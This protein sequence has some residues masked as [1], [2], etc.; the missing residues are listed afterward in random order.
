M[1]QR[2]DPIDSWLAAP[3]PFAPRGAKLDVT[4][5]RTRVRLY[6]ASREVAEGHGA[7]IAEAC[8]DALNDI[9]RRAEAE[10]AVLDECDATFTR[11]AS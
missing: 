7:S 6:E 8:A 11:R 10:A 2:P 9:M 3:K 4:H 1:Q 5:G